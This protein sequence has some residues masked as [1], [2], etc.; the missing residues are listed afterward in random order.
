M[1]K[2]ILSLLLMVST[3]TY[4]ADKVDKSKA[5]V[6]PCVKD[7]ASKE[8]ED[9]LKKNRESNSCADDIKKFC[10]E[11]NSKNT[12]VDA[13]PAIVAT[14]KSINSCLEKNKNQLSKKC[15]QSLLKKIPMDTSCTDRCLNLKG[16]D[17]IT[18][19]AECHLK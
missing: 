4:S 5:L 2:L 16:D 6:N 1:K 18:C 3:L 13:K 19:L 9:L 7:A 12:S 15:S 10:I 11:D 17:Q 14:T 8:C